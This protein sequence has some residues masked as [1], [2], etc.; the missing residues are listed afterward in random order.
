MVP[1]L[2]LVACALPLAAQQSM[3]TTGNDGTT[4]LRIDLATGLATTIGP[5]GGSQ[6]WAGAFTS[7]G[8]FWTIQNGFTN[9]QL[10]RVDLTTGHATPVGSPM[11]KSN[12]IALAG[13]GSNLYA[14]GFDG[15]FYS[16]NQSTGALSLLGNM[17]FSDVMDMAETPDGQLFGLDGSQLWTIN[18]LNGSSAFF[19]SIAFGGAPMSMAFSDPTH[20]YINTYEANSRLFVMDITTK[21]ASFVGNTGAYFAHGG[22]I[23]LT[24]TT[25][26]PTSLLL[27]GS[28]L[29]GIYGAARRRRRNAD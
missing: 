26:E 16:V 12:V 2:A 18:P 8:S 28:G 20:L 6:T 27:L 1:A 10:A 9:G 13:I 29:V 15:N 17:G 11:G 5:S 24:T 14:G 23:L 25:P 21:S 7:D 19:A 3:Y 22:D 4:I